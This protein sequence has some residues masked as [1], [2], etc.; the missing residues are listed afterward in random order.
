MKCKRFQPTPADAL[1]SFFAA[2]DQSGSGQSVFFVGPC[3]AQFQLQNQTHQATQQDEKIM[4]AQAQHQ[5]QDVLCLIADAAIATQVMCTEAQ[6]V[7]QADMNTQD[8]QGI[9]VAMTVAA[10]DVQVSAPAATMPAVEAPAAPVM[11]MQA[12]IALPVHPAPAHQPAQG[13]D[14]LPG[15]GLGLGIELENEETHIDTLDPFEPGGST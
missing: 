7:A 3:Q 6:V 14:L 5:A 4:Q 15:L 13:L 10:A 2:Y 8:A 1:C 11:P 9:E 12:V